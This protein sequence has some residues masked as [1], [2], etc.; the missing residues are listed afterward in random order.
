MCAG[1]NTRQQLHTD[2]WQ[3]DSSKSAVDSTNTWATKI[4]LT[5]V[6]TRWQ[7]NNNPQLVIATQATNGRTEGHMQQTVDTSRPHGCDWT[8]LAESR[9]FRRQSHAE[10][11]NTSPS[12]ATERTDFSNAKQTCPRNILKISSHERSLGQMDSGCRLHTTTQHDLRA[13]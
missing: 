3:T 10:K 13:N 1:I 4:P 2:L 8:V 9:D 11:F 5:I 7:Q 6:S 12:L